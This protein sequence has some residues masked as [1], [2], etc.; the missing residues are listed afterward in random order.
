MTRLGRGKIFS[1]KNSQNVLVTLGVHF[2]KALFCEDC[3]AL[4]IKQLFG[5]NGFFLILT[6]SSIGSP[7]ENRLSNIPFLEGV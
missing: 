5:E 2:K 7:L 4:F 3:L 6:F 1:W